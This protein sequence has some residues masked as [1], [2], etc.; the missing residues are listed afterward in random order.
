[1][2]RRAAILAWL[3]LVAS[4]AASAQEIGRLFFTPEQRLALDARRKA[5]I[6][7]KPAAVVPESPVTR[8]DG[9]VRR[10]G[11]RSTVWLNGVAAPEHLQPEAIRIAPGKRDRLAVSV[12]VGEEARRFELKV[13]QNLDHASG[14]VRDVVGEDA[15]RVRRGGPGK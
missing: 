3:L 15:I 12:T 6:P 14:E 4:A 7:D 1:M 2:S 5:R 10:E 8:I 9:L 11:G 13:G